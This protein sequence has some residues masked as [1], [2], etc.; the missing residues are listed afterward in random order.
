M[1]HD[2]WPDPAVER[3]LTQSYVPV[4]IDVDTDHVSAGRYGVDSIPTILVLDATGTVVRRGRFLNAS[5][6]VELLTGAA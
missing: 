2:V 5:G 4:L 6:M 1:K 3:A